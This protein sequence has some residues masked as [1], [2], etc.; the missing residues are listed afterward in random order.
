MNKNNLDELDILLY[1]E[2]PFLTDN[3]LSNIPKDDEIEHVFSKEFESKMDSLIKE[4]EKK[5]SRKNLLKYIKIASISTLIIGLSGFF[6]ISSHA[7]LKDIINNITSIFSTHTSIELSKETNSY[8]VKLLKPSYIPR[9]YKKVNETTDEYTYEVVYKNNDNLQFAYT[10]K[11]INNNT[12]IFDT[13]N[14]D[15]KNLKINNKNATLIN[16][17]N[18]LT[19][20]YENENWFFII[21]ADLKDNSQL[22]LLTKDLIKV[23]ESV[24]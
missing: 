13:E 23:A 14:A 8:N 19:L 4:Q 2:M 10:C 24:K 5:S 22:N 15:I 1:K 18:L 3:I 9:G 11:S 7:S 12:F 17:N 21:R 6:N 20:Y 16:K